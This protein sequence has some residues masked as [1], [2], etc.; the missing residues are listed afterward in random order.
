MHEG[1]LS[2]AAHQVLE[3]GRIFADPL[4]L[5]ILGPDAQEAVAEA[6]PGQGRGGLRQF[7]AA[8]SRFAEDAAGRRLR[9][10]CGKSSCSAFRVVEDFGPAEITE[11]FFP[12]HPA[13]PGASG[14]VA[15]ARTREEGT[16]SR[17]RR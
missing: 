8:R 10:A 1:R 7:V 14:D 11:R 12:R 3:G 6:N 13:R 16:R 9:A 4:A 2:R 15:L 17:H 5:R